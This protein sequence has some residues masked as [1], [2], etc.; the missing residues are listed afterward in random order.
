LAVVIASFAACP[1]A[2]DEAA[3]T[4]VGTVTVNGKALADGSSIFHLDDHEFVGSKI[5]G[6]NYKVT[7]VPSGKWRVAIR[8]DE[9]PAKLGSEETSGFTVEVKPGMN[10]IDFDLKKQ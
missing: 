9:V 10:T 7:R 2:A 1:V 8:S 4:I 5:R 6:G 3:V